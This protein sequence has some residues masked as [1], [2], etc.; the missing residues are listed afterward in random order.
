MTVGTLFVNKKQ[1]KIKTFCQL[2]FR[3]YV[4]FSWLTL[5]DLRIVLFYFCIF[6]HFPITAFT[7]ALNKAS[8][9]K[10]SSGIILFEDFLKQ[11]NLMINLKLN[12]QRYNELKLFI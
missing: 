8:F 11:L 2:F 9:L 3:S 6:I 1:N 10:K 12:N 7:K 4:R 5:L